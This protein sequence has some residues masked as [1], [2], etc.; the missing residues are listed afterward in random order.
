MATPSGDNAG[1]SDVVSVPKTLK[2]LASLSMKELRRV[3]TALNVSVVGRATK[4]D[5]QYAL[6][7]H[8]KISTSGGC[9]TSASDQQL[10]KAGIPPEVLP[11]FLEVGDLASV[12]ASDN[13]RWTKD[14]R[15]VPSDFERSMIVDYLVSS[16]DKEFD[17]ESLR[18]Y[19]ALR[20]YQLFEERHIHN[21]EFCPSWPRKDPADKEDSPL[22]FLRCKCFPSQDTSKQPHRV[23]LCL[24]KRSGRPYGAHCRCVSGLGQACS[25]VAGLL[26]AL[27]D[28]VARGF[29]KL[30][31]G[32]STTDVL[33]VWSKPSGSQKVEPKPLS[34][35][36]IR[37]AVSGGRKSKTAWEREQNVSKYDPR[38]PKDR[39]IDMDA[40]AKLATA[41]KR[42]KARDCAFV[43]SWDD[44]QARKKRCSNPISANL[45]NLPE[46]A[47]DVNCDVGS[48]LVVE[49]SAPVQG[50]E[51]E[52]LI[53][54]RQVLLFDSAGVLPV[55]DCDL[56]D[57]IKLDE[58]AK[59][60]IAKFAVTADE[61]DLLEEVTRSQ[62]ANDRWHVEH[63]GRI[64]ASMVHRAKNAAISKSPDSFI[65]DIMKYRTADGK[66]L[67]GDDP[68][69]HGLR[70]EGV[71]RDAYIAMMETDGGSVVVEEHG[72]FVSTEFPFLATSTDGLI[73]DS[74]TSGKGVLEIKCPVGRKQIRDLMASRRNFC[75]KEG[76]DGALSL[77]KTHA[78]HTQVQFE[79]AITGCQW[80]DFVV[81]SLLEDDD[82]GLNYDIFIQRVSFSK[83]FWAETLLPALKKSFLL[84]V[85]ELLT[86]RVHRGV[87]LLPK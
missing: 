74:R 47:F 30:P 9:S 7:Q 61:R 66:P 80:A 33:C 72:L 26:F 45:Q 3:G 53:A 19:K 57:S 40:V 65:H 38:R 29:T 79:M 12:C 15:S 41:L 8:L 83:Q 46:P 1:A 69:Q 14:L 42:S 64:T 32:Q 6:C 43:R 70:T 87:P 82:G 81:F 37:K 44:Y 13:K 75:L 23:V 77:R 60:I 85:L 21:V 27:E 54:E 86:R 56:V 48:E 52:R 28:F 16:P 84:V 20:A 35:V 78:Y 18:S 24:D 10:L 11:F 58:H 71:A 76:V 73:S 55:N 59:R 36:T 22:C 25:H 31:D 17:G 2:E 68:R 34:D 67:S 51:R 5:W 50:Q 49:T 63:V 4:V 39:P 62:S